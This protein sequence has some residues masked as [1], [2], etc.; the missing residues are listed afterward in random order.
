M[1]RSEQGLQLS[2]CKS[3]LRSI[4]KLVG[5][6]LDVLWLENSF[7]VLRFSVV[8]AETC[9]GIIALSRV[10][11]IDWCTSFAMVGLIVSVI[12]T[13]M[14]GIISSLDC[15]AQSIGRMHTCTSLLKAASLQGAYIQSNGRL[16]AKFEETI[17]IQVA[18]ASRSSVA[19]TELSTEF[20][21]SNYNTMLVESTF[22][23]YLTNFYIYIIKCSIE[24]TVVS[25]WA[26]SIIS[27][28]QLKKNTQLRF[29]RHFIWWKARRIAMSEIVILPALLNPSGQ[30]I[31]YV[32]DIC[33]YKWDIHL[34]QDN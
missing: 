7:G 19:I 13:I 2:L 28:C 21:C 20:I 9:F 27:C 4:R 16:T 17:Q 22:W 23:E 29:I 6:S 15:K 8:Y 34:N 24:L 10:D 32:W 5:V 11:R 26:A 30:Q 33:V 31:F 18:Y 12:H 3:N 1:V 25:I 14:L